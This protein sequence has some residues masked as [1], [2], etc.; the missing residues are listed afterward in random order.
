MAAFDVE[1]DICALKQQRA[2]SRVRDIVAKRAEYQ[3][4]RSVPRSRSSA[5]ADRVKPHR[6]ART[7]ARSFIAKGLV[8][9]EA[10]MPSIT[11]MERS[12]SAHA[13][14]KPSVAASVS[15]GADPFAEETTSPL[16]ACSDAEVAAFLGKA[17]KRSV[18]RIPG[19]APSASDVARAAEYKSAVVEQKVQEEAE[20]QVGEQDQQ[21]DQATE[22]CDEDGAAMG[23]CDGGLDDICALRMRRAESRKR[24]IAAKRV[25]YQRARTTPRTRS[26]DP[27]DRVKP[28]RIART[29]AR[30]F[31]AKGFVES[32]SDMPSLTSMGKPSATH[33]RKKPSVASLVHIGCA[34]CPEKS[35]F[36]FEDGGDGETT[37]SEGENFDG[38]LAALGPDIASDSDVSADS[39]LVVDKTSTEELAT[40]QDGEKERRKTDTVDELQREEA[41]NSPKLEQAEGGWEVLSTAESCPCK[42]RGSSKSWWNIFF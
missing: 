17:F 34:S 37:A 30:S 31:V 3:R 32:E 29:A 12:T 14:K 42:S 5:P 38:A 9:G 1:V 27:A 35:P 18:V 15:C 20:V 40:L 28:H 25:D 10:D 13:R 11:A 4:A 2:K 6:L 36:G 39:K 26:S 7:A 22:H 19:L 41:A 23:V 24:D 16:N 33:N 8:K 21:E